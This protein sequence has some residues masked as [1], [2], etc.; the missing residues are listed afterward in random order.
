MQRK[1]W[2]LICWIMIDICNWIYNQD[3]YSI[4]NGMRISIVMLLIEIEYVGL[5]WQLRSDMCTECFWNLVIVINFLI[6]IQRFA[7]VIKFQSEIRYSEW[8]L[9]SKS[10][11]CISK[12]NIHNWIGNWT[13]VFILQLW[14]KVHHWSGSWH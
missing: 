2:H 9:Q 1:L 14:K 13:L 3:F 6:R 7:F 5:N 12:V 8:N 11:M 4:P 10:N